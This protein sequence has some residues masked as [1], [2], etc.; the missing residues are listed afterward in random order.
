MEKKII[1]DFNQI[2]ERLP[3]A[4]PFLFIDT[5]VELIPH[6]LIVSTK[7]IT[8]NEW[9]FP[10]HF[11]TKAVYPGVLLQESM[12][13]SSILLFQ[14]SYKEQPIIDEDRMWVLVGIKSR[15]LKPV[16]PGDQV[17]FTCKPSKMLSSGS[18]IMESE[19]HVNGDQAVKSTLTVT[20][21]PKH[22][23]AAPQQDIVHAI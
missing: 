11:P 10:G 3:H 20:K 16:E 8:G 5:V 9:M 15:F 22:T 21:A 14:E 23:K 6:E 17:I 2:R 12:A 4:H 7:N 18:I 19:G 13:Q 1:F